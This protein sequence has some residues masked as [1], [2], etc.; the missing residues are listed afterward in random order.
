MIKK[1][2]FFV[3]LK[4]IFLVRDQ[5]L[6]KYFLRLNSQ[7]RI[8][9]AKRLAVLIE[10]GAPIVQALTMMAA[11]SGSRASGRILRSIVAEVNN[12]QFL[13]SAMSK[14]PSVFGGFA[15]NIVRIGEVSGT[16]GE[17]LSY[18]A[19]ELKKNRELK[20]KVVSALVYPAVIV[21]ATFGIAG[22][23]AVY[24]LPKILPIFQSFSTRLPLSTRALIF[25]SNFISGRWPYILISLAAA[26]FAAGFLLRKSYVKRRFD[27]LVL[28]LPFLGRMLQSYC[29][30]NFCRTLGLLLKSDVRLEEAARI[31]AGAAQNQVYKN[32]LLI[33]ADKILKGQKLSAHMLEHPKIFPSVMAQMIS[34]GETA[35]SLSSGL[36]YLSAMYEDELGDLTKNLSTVIEPVLMIFM[37]LIVG[38][39]AVSIIMPIYGI[40]QNL[41]P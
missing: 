7:E 34:V 18:L 24:V 10:A 16:L 21:V 35:G 9:F 22:L 14:F 38:F 33:L 39:V 6:D 4:N 20:R 8:L 17:N 3:R 11:Q 2:F 1:Q 41:H 23:L 25:I 37:G 5:L 29:L 12:G 32:H 36:L 26:F 30:A 15:L 19:E 40:T 13:S 31:A 27:R 28:R